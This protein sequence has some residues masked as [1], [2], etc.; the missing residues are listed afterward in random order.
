MTRDELER[1][2]RYLKQ[3]LTL[4]RET[5]QKLVDYAL[6]T[7]PRVHPDGCGW[8]RGGSCDCAEEAPA[9]DL[10]VKEAL[11]LVEVR[12]P[13]GRYI[14]RKEAPWSEA[15]GGQVVHPSAIDTGECNE[16]CCDTFK[17]PHCGTSWKSEVAQ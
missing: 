2:A 15:I 7:K 4:D 11:T 17:C 5:Q 10:R 6:G 8:W 16:G 12:D 13:Q 3:G 1:C 14:C 9:L